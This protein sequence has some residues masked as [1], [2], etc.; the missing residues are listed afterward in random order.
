[1]RYEIWIPPA[2]LS[3]CAQPQGG[4]AESIIE[5]IT[6][7]LLDRGDRGRRW[8]RFWV[9]HFPPTPHLP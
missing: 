3:F 4:V 1:F 9:E 8:V 7:S 6:L 5:R 2:M